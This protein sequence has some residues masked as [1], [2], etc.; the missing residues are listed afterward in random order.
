MIYYF[1]D[2]D[3]TGQGSL[4]PAAALSLLTKICGR[5]PFIEKWTTHVATRTGARKSKMRAPHRDVAILW[6]GGG[7]VVAA[8]PTI[9][10]EYVFFLD[11]RWAMENPPDEK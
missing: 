7:M 2:L 5:P 4:P 3:S 8:S 1:F 9:C 11:L 10:C 6:I